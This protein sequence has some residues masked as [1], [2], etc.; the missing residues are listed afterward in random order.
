MHGGDGPRGA[1]GAQPGA[2]ADGRRDGRREEHGAQG[3]QAGGVVGQRGGQQRRRGGGGRRV[4]G[5]GRH[6]PR[7]QLHGTPQRHAPD[8]RAGM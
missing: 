8:G 3:D 5:D 7:H 6:L 2:A 4:Q 1:L